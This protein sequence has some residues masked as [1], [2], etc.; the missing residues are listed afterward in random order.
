MPSFREK[1]ISTK[2]SQ[3]GNGTDDSFISGDDSN[4]FLL[5]KHRM[6]RAGLKLGENSLSNISADTVLQGRKRAR[7]R[8][9]HIYN[10]ITYITDTISYQCIWP[11]KNE[12]PA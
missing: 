2:S 7:K 9:S 1:T 11:H 8:V 4:G 3:R 12:V 6:S 5:S 10:N